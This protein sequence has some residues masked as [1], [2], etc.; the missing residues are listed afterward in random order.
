[1]DALVS[2]A[3]VTRLFKLWDPAGVLGLP[4]TYEARWARASFADYRDDD[5][6]L[7][8]HLGRLRRFVEDLRSGAELDPIVLD[9]DCDRGR[10]YPNVI[11]IDGNHRLLSYQLAGRRRIPVAYS[12]RVDLLRYLEGRR[13]HPPLQ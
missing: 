5:R 9:N 4:V 6:D 12:G 3:L 10:V 1:M 11:V 7:G 2:H 13:A 8:Y